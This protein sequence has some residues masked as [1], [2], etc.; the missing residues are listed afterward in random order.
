MSSQEYQSSVINLLAEHERKI[1]ELYKTYAD[2]F[3]DRR[4]FWLSLSEEELQHVQ[5]LMSLNE[6]IKEGNV[7]FDRQRFAPEA[8]KSSLEEVKRSISEVNKDFLPIQALSTAYY[9]EIA[10]IEKKFFEVFEGDSVELKNTLIRLSEA[11]RAHQE[12]IKDSLDKEREKNGI[13]T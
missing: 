1:S 4:D 6:K 5:W 10:L 7:Y 13:K 9:F 2:N 8:I 11:T 3:H 12:K